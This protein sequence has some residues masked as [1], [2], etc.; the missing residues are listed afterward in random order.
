V[1]AL[2]TLLGAATAL[3]SSSITKHASATVV[4]AAGRTR[5]VTVP[6]PDAL[7]YANA[8][9]SGTS[10]VLGPPPGSH[11]SAPNRS[12][13]EILSAASALGGSEYRVRVRNSNPA[14]TAPVRVTV[15]ATTVEPLP[16]S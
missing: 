10:H 7:E 1:A 11:G 8:R 4:L 12:D 9:Y 14:G 16:H 3:A 15:V 5:T 2:L 6:Y 13:V